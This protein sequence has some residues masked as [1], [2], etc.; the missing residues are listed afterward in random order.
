M[1]PADLVRPQPPP[2]HATGDVWLDLI[3]VADVSNDLR[4]AMEARRLFGIAKHGTP[5]Q[6]A[7]GRHH[8]IDGLQ[9][10]LDAA[11]YFDAD[12]ERAF[13]LEVLAFADRVMARLPATP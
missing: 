6:R 8:G 11:V 4:A 2:V 10:L 5:V 13:A 3:A 1:S 7:N 12:D 9:E